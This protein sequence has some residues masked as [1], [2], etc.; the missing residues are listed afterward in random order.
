[1]ERRLLSPYVREMQLPDLE[2]SI[3]IADQALEYYHS[4]NRQFPARCHPGA[5]VALALYQKELDTESRIAFIA[6]M[7]GQTM[8]GFLKVVSEAR[9]LLN[10]P[11]NISFDELVQQARLPTRLASTARKVFEDLLAAIPG[12]TQLRRSAVYA[13]V[14]LV[15]A[16]KRGFKKLETLADLSRITSS[17]PDDVL[18]CERVIR[19]ILAR[20][21]GFR[22]SE[23]PRAVHGEAADE[24]KAISEQTMEQ[25]RTGSGPKKKMVQRKLGFALIPRREPD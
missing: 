5:C 20:K 13:A 1:M 17:D 6:K 24:I 22:S 14:M 2:T 15:V 8:E 23:K 9:H 4:L 19:D 3:K 18:N 21:Y 7:S 10:I 16:V 25:M 12:D 11:V